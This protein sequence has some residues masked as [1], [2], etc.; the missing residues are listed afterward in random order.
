MSISVTPIP[1]LIDLAAPAFTLGTA[2]A[3]GSAATAVARDSTLLAFDTTI[4]ADII[5][6]TSTVGSA[7]VTARRDHVHG[8]GITY[9]TGTFTPV[10]SD[11]SSPVSKSQAYSTQVGVYTK[12][13]RLV[14][15]YGALAM[16]SLGSLTTGNAASLHGLPATAL[17]TGSANPSINISRGDSLGIT[18]LSNVAGMIG[19]G[20]AYVQ[21]QNWDASTGT[22][23][24]LI[25]EL[26][27][28]GSFYFSGQMYT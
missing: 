12:I 10:I 4:P 24:F 15:F 18:A 8:G 14:T 27:A 5:S 7:T 26:S 20:T 6:G 25:S 3:A 17:S 13:G 21:L 1:S 22:S 11:S 23:G 28:N 16:S 2:N 19:A 9:E